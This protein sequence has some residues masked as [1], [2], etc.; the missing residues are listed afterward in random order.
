MIDK[1]NCP[2]CYEESKI[3]L[4]D[5][6]LNLYRCDFCLHT[7]TDV[8]KGKEEKY[9]YDYYMKTHRNWINNPNYPLFNFINEEL[10]RLFNKKPIRILDVGCGDGTFLRYL[11]ARYPTAET[12]GI[13]LK[14]NKHPGIN[15]IKGDFLNIDI[16]TKFDA[17]RSLAS[18][19][20]MS[21]INLFV[22]KIYTHLEPN[23]VAFIMTLD[24]NSLI[25]RIARILNKVGIRMAYNRLYSFH[26]LHHFTRYSF[27]KLLENNNFEV[28]LHKN[29]NYPIKSV[30]VPESNFLFNKIL[31]LLVL[32]IYL[33][34]G[35]F[36]K[37]VQ[38]TI[39]CRRKEF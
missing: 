20:H 30:D 9:D 12:S 35:P 4:R 28:L 36:G 18:I 14:A 11:S 1:I 22:K 26:H 29:H 8:P 38:Q 31:K 3:T 6:R 15:F 19:E 25:Y 33:L 32:L 39:V 24:E 10:L 23:G 2:I 5:S 27:R 21:D 34:S 37:G 7:F 13:D 16:K 17:I